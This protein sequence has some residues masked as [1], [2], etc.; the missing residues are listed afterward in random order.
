VE[1]KLPGR[2]FEQTFLDAARD[3]READAGVFVNAIDAAAQSLAVRQGS[4]TLVAALQSPPLS[5]DAE[6]DLIRIAEFCRANAIRVVVF[7]PSVGKALGGPW[8]KFIET[9]G[10][11]FVSSA[12]AI[13]AAIRGPAPAPGS[14]APA[15][16]DPST[17][18][19][20]GSSAISVH[21]R[22]VRTSPRGTLAYGVERHTS[23]VGTVGGGGLVTQE[24]GS[25]VES[26]TGPVRG[27]FLV[28][29]PLRDL[30]F[31]SLENGSYLAK[32]RVTQVARNS[33]G[34][35]V[36]T[37]KKEVVIRGPLAKLEER[38]A[39]NLYY[40]RDVVLPGRRYTLEATVEDLLAGKSGTVKEPLRTGDG[41]PGFM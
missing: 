14:T 2:E 19:V 39:G 15:E 32:A 22:F 13:Q 21:T 31:D 5:G 33:E 4:R 30:R 41:M 20:E 17:Q 40:L 27:M 12:R 16:S 11:T 37:A 23:S 10:G 26:A 28:E 8:T 29:A 18:V 24:G 6:S 35:A 25:N 1:A 7:D 34:K 3:S 38:R 9:S 36:W